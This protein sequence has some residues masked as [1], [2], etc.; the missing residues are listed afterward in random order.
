MK[1]YF[2][3]CTTLEEVKKAYYSLAKANHPDK[4]GDAEIMKAINN[5]YDFAI[6]KILKGGSFSSE[7]INFE[8]ELSEIYREKVQALAAVEGIVIELVGKWLWISGN[9]F[10]VK[11]AIKAAGFFWAKKKAAWF[12]RPEDAKSNS[13]KSMPL[14][15]IKAKYGATTLKASSGLALN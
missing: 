8:S 3:T 6:A 5:A 12:W 1:N 9:T 2:E 15:E 11:D 10:P 4:G 14:E 13:R 7:E